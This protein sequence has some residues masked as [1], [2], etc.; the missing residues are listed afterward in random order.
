MND[1]KDK[2]GKEG[3]EEN[4]EVNE[5]ENY[6][7]LSFAPCAFQI[8]VVHCKANRRTLESSERVNMST[9]RLR[10]FAVVSSSMHSTQVVRLSD[11]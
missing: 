9:A 1:K 2:E 11:S 10:E 5:E 8:A 7:P 6:L 3:K 4:E